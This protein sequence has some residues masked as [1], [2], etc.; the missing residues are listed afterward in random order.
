[1]SGVRFQPDA[2]PPLSPCSEVDSTAFFTAV[3]VA[4]HEA[5]VLSLHHTKP[6]P[7]SDTLVISEG[8]AQEVPQ[9]LV[10]ATAGVGVNHCTT[11]TGSKY[12]LICR[13]VGASAGGV[14]LGGTLEYDK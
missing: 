2:A 9:G 1:M 3:G 12:G 4:A 11:G 13:T 14:L 7:A 10:D 6:K 5:I 8:G